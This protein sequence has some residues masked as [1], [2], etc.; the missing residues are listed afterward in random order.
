MYPPAP[1]FS[2]RKLVLQSTGLPEMNV[3]II[4]KSAP[5]RQR[6]RLSV[7]E[8]EINWHAFNNIL[9]NVS[10]KKADL[11]C[12]CYCVSVAD[13][14]CQIFP[15]FLIG[16]LCTN[17]LFNVS[18]PIDVKNTSP[19]SYQLQWNVGWRWCE[20]RMWYN[21]AWQQIP[22]SLVRDSTD[23]LSARFPFLP[24]AYRPSHYSLSIAYHPLPKL[25]AHCL[26]HGNSSW[27]L[28]Q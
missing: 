14:N 9:L 26:C 15:R 19:N 22:A 12:D 28:N 24:I 11:L 23:Q 17:S 2:S 18:R 5:D 3:Q 6:L 16:T 1:T 4:V 27:F 13:H 25:I 8:S 21:L 10:R 7:W 20:E